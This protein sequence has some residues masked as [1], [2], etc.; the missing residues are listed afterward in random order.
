MRMFKSVK[1]KGA[2]LQLALGRA[3]G[4]VL[5]MSFLAACS[6]QSGR[7]AEAANLEAAR[8]AAQQAAA[9]IVQQQEA[10][11]AAEVARQREEQREEQARLQA[12]REQREAE[13]RARAEQEQRQRE[14]AERREQER[15]AAI[16]AVQ[17]ERQA[18]VDR[19]AELEQQIA[20][21][22]DTSVSD[23][24]ST[25]IL[26]QAITVAEELLVVLSEEQAKYEETDAQGNTLEPLEKDLIAE[27]QERKDDLVRRARAQ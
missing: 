12:Q 8:V 27:L 11:D 26:L 16:A 1:T 6:T 13:V 20:S 2:S 5:L 19:I 7:E 17:A 4:G 18:K 23:D 22:A 15:L 24:G 10:A 9:Q 14:V 25:E 21:F 3:I